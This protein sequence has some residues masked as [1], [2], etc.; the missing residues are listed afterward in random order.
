M[1]NGKGMS[2]FN[3]E[4]QNANP[5][6][7]IVAGLERLSQVYRSLLWEKAKV[8][9]LSPIQ[10]QIL[11]FIR[12]HDPSLSTVSALA[13]E[14]SVTK[15]T[16][17]DAIRV[18]LEK[19]LLVKRP[20][21]TDARSFLV[22]LTV[23]GKRITDNMEQYADPIAGLIAEMDPN[24]KTAL[25]KYISGLISQLNSAGI[26]A[27]QRTCFHCRYFGEHDDRPFCNLLGKPLAVQDIRIDCPEFEPGQSR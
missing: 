4:E 22:H 3:I 14:F 26:I 10:I 19:D 7:K 12:Y 5:D 25:W 23:K 15:P 11:I 1:V 24:E 17:S 13:Q 6:L 8:I 18:L 9:G 20:N 16:I 21:P 2:A 27:V